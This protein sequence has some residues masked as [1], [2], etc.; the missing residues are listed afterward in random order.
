[1]GKNDNIPC[2]RHATVDCYSSLSA[3]APIFSIGSIVD[4]S[5]TQFIKLKIHWGM[6]IEIVGKKKMQFAWNYPNPQQW[7]DG[8]SDCSRIKRSR[9]RVHKNEINSDRMISRIEKTH[10]TSHTIW[11]FKIKSLK[12]DSKLKHFF[13][14]IWPE[15]TQYAFI[16]K[17]WIDSI[18][19]VKC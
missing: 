17:Q 18:H 13:R 9:L 8:D 3:S 15:H 14:A 11:K 10:S 6:F 7:V 4:A 1:M 5:S 16:P 12:Y 19:C 2:C